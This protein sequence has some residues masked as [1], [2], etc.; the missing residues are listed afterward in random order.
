MD[1][2]NKVKDIKGFDVD[3]QKIVFKGKATNNTD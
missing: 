2:K 3:T 1:L